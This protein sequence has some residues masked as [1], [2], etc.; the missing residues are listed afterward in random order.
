MKEIKISATKTSLDVENLKRGMRY[1]FKVKATTS[2]GSGD[3]SK[4]Y[5]FWMNFQGNSYV[6]ACLLFNT[7]SGCQ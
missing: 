3:F 7:G 1:I 6:T 5:L 4:D 2:A